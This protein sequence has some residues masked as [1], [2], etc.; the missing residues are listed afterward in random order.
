MNSKWRNALTLVFLGWGIYSVFMMKRDFQHTTRLT[1]F[2]LALVP[3][4][5]LLH[6]VG[7]MSTHHEARGQTSPRLKAVNWM[8]QWLTQNMTQYILMFSLPFFIVTQRWVYLGFTLILLA[9]TLWDD[10]WKILLPITLYRQLLRLWS[11]LCAGS[12]LYPFVWPSHLSYFYLSMATGA[13]LALFPTR[14]DRTHLLS[15]ALLQALTLI[16]LL[17]LPPA[18][19]FPLLSVWVNKPHFA[20]NEDQK[21]L[22]VQSIPRQ[23]PLKEFKDTLGSGS[24]I[25]CVAPV[26]APPGVRERV[27]QEWTLEGQLLEKPQLKSTIRGNVDQRGFH[28]FFC[29][30]NFPPAHAQNI[31]RCRLLLQETIFLGEST[32]ILQ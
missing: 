1:I 11:I 24:S 3:V 5:L 13:A 7:K 6:L 21:S 30:R 25:C 20:T 16:N 2:L 4:F 26:V 9:T 22:G 14:L 31:L 27:T 23:W 19:R 28:S 15:S 12:F 29:K 32:L 17:V 8:S 10:W 18:F